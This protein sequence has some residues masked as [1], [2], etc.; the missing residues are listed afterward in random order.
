LGRRWRWAW[1]AGFGVVGVGL[2]LTYSRGAMLGLAV[3]VGLLA[4]ARYR[5]LLWLA[6][7]AGVV[8]AFL[9]ATQEYVVHLLE[10]VRGED[11]ATQMRFGEYRDALTL[12]SRYPWIGVGFAGAPDL[13]IYLGVANAY[14][15]IASQM[16]F[17][18]LGVFALVLAVIFGWAFV[19]RRHVRAAPHIEPLWLGLH[20]GLAAALVVGLFDHYFFNLDFQPAGTIFWV[21]AGLALAA[22][23]LARAAA[24]DKPRNIS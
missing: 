22:T 13:D 4:A 21:F 11:L 14:L 20:A 24:A 18:G 3:A 12:I 15:T 16:G 8:V 9:P 17:V 5:P 1:Y 7:A 10:G 2:L 23:R 6:L 19:S